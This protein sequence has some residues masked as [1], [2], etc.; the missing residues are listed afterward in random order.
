MLIFRGLAT[1]IVGESVPITSL[2]FRGIARNYLPNI[3][4]WWGP[5]DGLTIVLGILC[6]VALPGASCASAP[7]WPRS[8]WCPSR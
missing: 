2:E 1:V 5:F 6:I 4:G 8:A 3:L 7:V